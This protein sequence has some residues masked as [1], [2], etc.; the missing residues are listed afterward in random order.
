METDSHQF[1]PNEVGLMIGDASKARKEL[2]WQP[3]T[4]FEAL[5]KLMVDAELKALE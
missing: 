1:R 5:V 3:R 2:D 4:R